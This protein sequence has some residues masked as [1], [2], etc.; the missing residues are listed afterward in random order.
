VL[1]QAPGTGDLDAWLEALTQREVLAAHPDARFPSTRQYGFRHG[2]LRDAAYAMLTDGDRTVGHCL[3]GEWLERVGESDPLTIAEHFERG[4]PLRAAPWL[5]RAARLASDGGHLEAADALAT[6]GLACSPAAADRGRLLEVKGEVLAARGQW[7]ESV[8]FHQEGMA[9]AVAGEA[10]WYLSAGFLMA[11]ASYFGD[12][13]L[14]GST[15]QAVLS[16]TRQPEPSGPYGMAI[17]TICSTLYTVGQFDGSVEILARAEALAKATADPDP[18]FVLWLCLTRAHMAAT[19]GEPGRALALLAEAAPLLEYTLFAGDFA[20]VIRGNAFGLAGRWD[21]TEAAVRDLDSPSAS[22]YLQAA[23]LGH[24]LA[25]QIAGRAAEAL[26]LADSLL[27]DPLPFFS[28]GARA[29]RAHGLAEIGDFDG[30]EAEARALLDSDGV[31]FGAM[32]FRLLSVL[33]RVALGRARADEALAFASQALDC[34]PI[35]HVSLSLVLSYRACALDA[36]GRRAEACADIERARAEI[37]RVASTFEDTEIRESFLRI[38]K[39]AT[40]FQLARDWL[41]P[42]ASD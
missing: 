13:A 32:R 25:N 5:H 4:D 26:S 22:I 38:P 27:D 15:M 34:A 23:R 14:F 6:R 24:A 36:L 31:F 33:A 30:A 17:T 9:L 18:A 12:A 1:G 2:T 11:A 3:A 35:G 16:L 28:N 37:L 10:G 7:R 21:L 42:P 20:T 8:E 29:I 40:V 41:R 39:S 19:D